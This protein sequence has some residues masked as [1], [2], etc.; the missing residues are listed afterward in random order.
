M[1]QAEFP[2]LITI[3]PHS[4]AAPEGLFLRFD[5]ILFQ[6]KIKLPVDYGKSLLQKEPVKQAS[7][8]QDDVG[9]QPA[10][11]VVCRLSGLK[12][13]DLPKAVLADKGVGAVMDAAQRDGSDAPAL[14]VTVTRGGLPLR[15][16]DAEHADLA[17]AGHADGIA[18]IYP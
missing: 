11:G 1:D 16:V 10:V 14:E 6:R 2:A 18:I 8:G 5:K 12:G 17:D 13:N 4:P 15:Y 9:E 7:V 3:F